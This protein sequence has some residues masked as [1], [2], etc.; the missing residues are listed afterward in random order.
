MQTLSCSPSV[1]SCTVVSKWENDLDD[2]RKDIKDS[3]GAPALGGRGGD[4]RQIN[5]VIW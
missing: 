2:V 5:Y 4:C 1:D 3:G